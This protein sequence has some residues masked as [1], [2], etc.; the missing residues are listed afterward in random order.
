[1][2]FSLKLVV[3]FAVSAIAALMLSGCGFHLRGSDGAPPTT[4][5]NYEY[6][7]TIRTSVPEFRVNL[8]E[9]LARREFNLVE[10]GGDYHVEIFDEQYNEY[11]FDLVDDSLDLV[12]RAL[13]YSIKFQLTKN[14]Q[15]ELVA[16]QT[17]A[18]STDYSRIGVR[19]T[20]RDAATRAA[21]QRSRKRVA[22]LLADRLVALTQGT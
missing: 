20:V 13:N 11:D 21:L 18:I 9:S 3:K 14:G 16:S 12:I 7:I 10:H 1:M 17:I 22:N 2:R 6:S 19:E 4:S 5:V 15:D 8:A